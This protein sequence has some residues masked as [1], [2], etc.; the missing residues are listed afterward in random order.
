MSELKACPYCGGEAYHTYDIDTDRDDAAES[1][2]RGCN[3]WQS[4]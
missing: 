4:R 1:W 3:L 2:N